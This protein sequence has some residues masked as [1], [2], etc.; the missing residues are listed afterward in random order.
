MNIPISILKKALDNKLGGNLWK[1]YETETL[2][3]EVG[4]P[5]SDILFDKLAVLKVIEHK[6]K[7]FFE[8][9]IFMINAA[10]VMNNNSADFEYL[11]HITS[12]E[13]AFAIVDMAATLDVS[14]HMLPV[15]EQGPVM[16]IRDILINEGYSKVLPPFDV[17]GIGQLAEGQTQQ[18]TADKEK[19]I[20]DYIYANYNQPTS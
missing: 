8:D 2:L 7:L 11:P 4:L 19:A 14:I 16:Y 1:D 9:V 17:V 12:L 15:F 3:Y 20:K 18:D 10:N 5:Y 6:P 13:M